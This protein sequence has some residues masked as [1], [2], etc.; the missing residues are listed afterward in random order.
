MQEDSEDYFRGYNKFNYYRISP[1]VINN[2]AE[3]MI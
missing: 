3:D 1:Y 2:L